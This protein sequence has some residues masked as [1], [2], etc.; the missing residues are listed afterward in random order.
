LVLVPRDRDPFVPHALHTLPDPS[1]GEAFEALPGD[2]LLWDANV[3]HWGGASSHRAQGPRI[4]ATYTCV[5]GDAGA[6]ARVEP[7]TLS[8]SQRL[9]LISDQIAT[10]HGMEAV[11]HAALGWAR[12]WREISC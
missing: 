1:L 2:A 7:K 11:P 4:S 3:A 9:T 6:L 5:V 10:Y 12:V 8:F